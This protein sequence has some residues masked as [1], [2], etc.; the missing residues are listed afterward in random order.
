MA[1]IVTHKKSGDRYILIGSGLGAFKVTR[2]GTFF[3]N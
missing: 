2:P 1:V 3:G